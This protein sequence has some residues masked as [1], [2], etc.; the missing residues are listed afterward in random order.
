MNAGHVCLTGNDRLKERITYLQA[1]IAELEKL[2]VVWH[3]YPDEKPDNRIPRPAGGMMI[4][5]L[6]AMISLLVAM[7][8]ALWGDSTELVIANGFLAVCNMIMALI[9]TIKDKKDK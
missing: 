4:W 2:A 1:R 9:E 7:G 3:K 5:I 8:S 6:L